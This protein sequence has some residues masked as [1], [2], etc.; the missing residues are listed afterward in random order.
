MIEI[1]RVRILN[2]PLDRVW[3]LIQPVERLPEWFSGIEAVR[4][5][6][7][8]GLGRRQRTSGRWGRH[9]FEIDQ[10]ITQYQQG[11]ALGWRHDA[12]RVD[13]K[14]APSLSRQ[15]EFQV[16]LQAVADGT[17]VELTSRQ[18]PGNAFKGLLIRLVAVPRIARM[19][20]GSLDKIAAILGG[21]SSE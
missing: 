19:M 7:G 17:R 20:D 1:T 16:Q 12:E 5:L 14:A 2:A 10:T 18:V 3:D 21:K 6:G 11:R 8:Q 9:R 4:L 15:T 13:G